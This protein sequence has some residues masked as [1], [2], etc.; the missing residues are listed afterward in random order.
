MVFQSLSYGSQRK[1]VPGGG[2]QGPVP[3]THV[4]WL[5]ATYAHML[6]TELTSSAGRSYVLLTTEPSLEP[7]K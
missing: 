5:T 1:T 2:R 7:Q 4:M 6:G 3:N